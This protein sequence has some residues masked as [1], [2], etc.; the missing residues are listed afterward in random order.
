MDNVKITEL[1]DIYIFW[2]FITGSGTFYVL[3]TSLK[4]LQ[5]WMQVLRF[6]FNQTIITDFVRNQKSCVWSIR[7]YAIVKFLLIC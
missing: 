4:P 2:T 5:N 1:I 3:Y 7:L 6:V